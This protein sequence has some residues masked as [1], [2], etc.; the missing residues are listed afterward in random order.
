MVVAII[1]A[2]AGCHSINATT[3]STGEFGTNGTP[4]TTIPTMPVTT[5]SATNPVVPETTTPTIPP[6]EPTEPTVPDATEPTIPEQTEPEVTEPS[7][8]DITLS[9]A[10]DFTL[11]NISESSTWHGFESFV[12]KYGH[13]YFL[14]KVRPIFEADDFT[15]V[16]LECVLT[17][18]DLP[19][20]DKGEGTAFWFKSQ[21]SNVNIMSGSSVEGVSLSNNH[22]HDYGEDG[23][24]DTKQ[25][26]LGAGLQYGTASNI[27]YFEKNGFTVAVICHGLW[28]ESQAN[29]IA[30]LIKIAEEKSNYQVVFY[31]GG[32]EKLHAPEEWRVRASRKLVDKGADL[33]IGNHPHVL[34][35]IE[36]YNGT[37]I[38]YSLG[39][40][41][42]GGH[43][44]PRNRTM[45]Y[46]MKL[47]I[48]TE[49]LELETSQ[50]NIIP[51]YVY[52]TKYNNY[53]PTPIEN[54]EE[55][56]RVLKFLNWELELPY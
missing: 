41:C 34:Q 11:S 28:Y 2:S 51:C 38:V 52:T 26:V 55:I 40:F 18:R 53:Q 19:K 1:W 3:P 46:Q 54:E 42:Y 56:E 31:H 49:T 24:S 37:Q 47:T 32:T 10:G 36:T 27:M 44:Q 48:N 33:V 12:T 35:P 29:E 5:P 45:I 39:N 30:R 25:A 43:L 16:N 14:E 13:D 17:D 9:F 6:S 20:R 8:F 7:S 21:A 15:I 4:D 23:H 22:S 50:Q